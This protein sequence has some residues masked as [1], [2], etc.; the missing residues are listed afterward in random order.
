MGMVFE[1]QK[2]LV[3]NEN[4]MMDTTP[5]VV[6]HGMGGISV[7]QPES[8]SIRKVPYGL[9]FRGPPTNKPHKKGF[10][11]CMVITGWSLL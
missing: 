9:P 4:P 6:D 10:A 1:W 11:W 8:T 5:Q 2:K 7:V 3:A